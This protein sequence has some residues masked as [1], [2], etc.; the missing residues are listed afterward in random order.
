MQEPAL[1]ST[2]AKL[3]LRHPILASHLEY[4]GTEAY[5]VG[6]GDGA[7]S[8]EPAL[9]VIPK[10]AEDDWKRAILAEHKIPF[11]RENGPLVRFIWLR[12][13]EASDIVIF[14]QHAIGDG[15]SLV[16]LARDIFEHLGCPGK[17]VAPLPLPPPVDET[18]IDPRLK[19]SMGT[20]LFGKLVSKKWA[21][22]ETMFDGRDFLALHEAF[23]QAFDYRVELLEFTRAET[24]RL[25]RSCRAHGV[26]VNTALVTAF[27]AAQVETHGDEPYLRKLGIAV[28]TR[29]SFL[30]T[31]GE[32]CGFF[33]S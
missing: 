27:L 18:N 28:D 17:D 22:I 9:K 32:Q 11:D 16:F 26:T 2:L 25:V 3:Q 8:V 1:R 29:R 5:L 33:A 23:W 14:C 15:M 10:G 4:E 20:R 24:D 19:P 31:V 21:G 13:A 7:R 30:Q 12:S 6:N